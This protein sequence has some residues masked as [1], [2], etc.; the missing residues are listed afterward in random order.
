MEVIAVKVDGLSLFNT[1]SNFDVLSTFIAPST[2]AGALLAAGFFTETIDKVKD[3]LL[4]ATWGV[5][6]DTKIIREKRTIMGYTGKTIE[7]KK[8]VELGICGKNENC[9]VPTHNAIFGNA[10]RYY[11]LYII[12]GFRNYNKE[13]ERAVR[14]IPAIGNNDSWVKV[15]EIT[16]LSEKIYPVVTIEHLNPSA[17]PYVQIASLKESVLITGNT[18]LKQPLASFNTYAIPVRTEKITYDAVIYKKINEPWKHVYR[19]DP[20][21]PADWKNITIKE[22][23]DK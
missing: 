23:N 7:K 15:K 21:L 19:F 2:I 13:I 20:P 12:F 6:D 22:V 14:S 10:F 8:L 9:R 1:F 3:N 17:L 18:I 11:D 16:E 5:G 4:L